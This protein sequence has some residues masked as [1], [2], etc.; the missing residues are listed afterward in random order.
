MAMSSYCYFV[1]LRL[2]SILMLEIDFS[3]HSS[4][5]MRFITSRLLL[6]PHP[7]RYRCELGS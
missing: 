6:M 5:D 4:A 3:N 1:H 7:E 2:S